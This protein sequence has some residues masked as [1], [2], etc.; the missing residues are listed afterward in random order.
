MAEA[1]TGQLQLPLL[2]FGVWPGQDLKE[3]N[4]GITFGSLA[5]IVLGDGD[6]TPSLFGAISGLLGDVDKFVKAA[7]YFTGEGFQEALAGGFMK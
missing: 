3:N 7:G 4:M 2:W 5:P 6:S 1:Q